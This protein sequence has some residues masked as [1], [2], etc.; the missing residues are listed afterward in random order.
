MTDLAAK[1]EA[2]WE[3]RDTVTPASTDVRAIVDEALELLDSGAARRDRIVIG[4]GAPHAAWLLT[5]RAG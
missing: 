2:A 3:A 4:S 1:I 5:L